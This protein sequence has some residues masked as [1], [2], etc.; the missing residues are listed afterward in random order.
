VDEPI[1]AQ[2]E[3]RSDEAS[4]PRALIPYPYPTFNDE[5]DLVDV[6]ASLWRRW[7]LM[8]AVFLVCVIVAVL[9]A[10]LVPRAYDYNTTIEI[11]SQVVGTQIKPIESADSAA[12]KLRKGY[13]PQVVA[14]YAQA[15]RLDPKKFGFNV[16]APSG[17][18]LV[19]VSGA[20]RINQGDH[21]MAIEK[22]AAGLLVASDAR[23]I[24]SQ[25]AQLTGKIAK[26]Q[27]KLVQLQSPANK[28]LLQA[29]AKNLKRYT[30]RARKQQIA[31]SGHSGG[32]SGAMAQLL[33]STQVQKAIQQLTTTQQTL[34]NLPS[35][36]ASQK[37]AVKSLQTQFDNIQQT[38]IVA[39]P[40]R[41]IE[42]TGLSR[43][44]IVIIGIV[45]G[46][47]L[48]LLAAG[49]ANYGVAVRRRLDQKA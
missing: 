45:V 21:F 12:S 22:A 48:A 38:Q 23:V 47:V 43:K 37:A 20:G 2:G 27:A 49:L 35:E 1:K 3:K 17:A 44:V 29:Q 31:S 13:L 8:L 32:A 42:P 6:G 18:N 10:F 5:V 7:K 40:M 11:G 30:S 34:N 15:H 25:Q 19:V 33:L 14:N 26:A 39:G 24:K 41:S 16:N 46:I 4:P 36:I 9:I 28:A